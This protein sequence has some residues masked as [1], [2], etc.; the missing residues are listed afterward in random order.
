MNEDST[1][2]LINPN[3]RDFPVKPTRID[4][5]FNHADYKDWRIKNPH[6]VF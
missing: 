2:Q 6:P 1:P 3:L 5:C 4:D